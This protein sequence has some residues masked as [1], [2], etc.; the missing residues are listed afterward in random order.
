MPNCKFF[1]QFQDAREFCTIFSPLFLQVLYFFTLSLTVY[2][3]FSIF[4]NLGFLTT[5]CG[6]EWMD[7]VEAYLHV[8]E[9]P[10]LHVLFGHGWV[11]IFILNY[12]RKK[13]L[14]FQ[15]LVILLFSL[16]IFLCTF[17]F[18]YDNRK[19]ANKCTGT[20][21]FNTWFNDWARGI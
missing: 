8:D 3:L 11:A 5:F 20:G 14:I 2:W 4:K 21:C 6:I 17:V 9:Y 15:K 10:F 18:S 16:K 1:Y 19:D 12:K 7:I 13:T